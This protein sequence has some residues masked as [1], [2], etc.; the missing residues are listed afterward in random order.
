[1]IHGI[2]CLD[3]EVLDSSLDQRAEVGDGSIGRGVEDIVA[4]GTLIALFDAFG[5][6]VGELRLE[7][8]FILGENRPAGGVRPQDSLKWS[9]DVL[10]VVA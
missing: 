3:D 10:A 7:C 8:G 1:M 6:V 9:A 4:P 5:K 2:H